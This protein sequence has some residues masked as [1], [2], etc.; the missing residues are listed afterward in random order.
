MTPRDLPAE[1]GRP[2][3]PGPLS[4][5]AGRLEQIIRRHIDDR[6]WPPGHEFTMA[7]IAEEFSLQLTQIPNIVSPVVVKLRN[8]GLLETRPGVGIRV[9]TQEKTWGIADYG[10]ALPHDQHIE[11]ILRERLYLG[12]YPP[13]KRFPALPHLAREFGVSPDTVRKAIRSMQSQGI[14][15]LPKSNIRFV[16]P[17][18]AH[19]PMEV[20]L[21]PPIRRRPGKRKLGAFGEEHTIAD[22]AVHPRC[23]IDRTTLYE[24]Y[25]TNWDLEAALQTPKNPVPPPKD[26]SLIRRKARTKKMAYARLNLTQALAALIEKGTLSPGDVIS[27][28][29]TARALRIPETRVPDVLDA[30]R[31]LH[32][33]GTLAHHP[34]AGFFVAY[35]SH[36]RRAAKAAHQR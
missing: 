35:T 14:F 17:A 7:N 27:P 19:L 10:S 32:R 20:L 16:S 13:D 21:H 36:N 6:K 2:L 11:R 25:A 9:V 12:I 8:D 24:R 15:E 34:T 33:Q 28:K 1:E 4:E 3:P 29:E 30:L 5:Q 31:E 23:V 18:V 26:P 22:W